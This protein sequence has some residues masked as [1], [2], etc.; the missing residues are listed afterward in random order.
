MSRLAGSTS[1]QIQDAG[2]TLP[3]ITLPMIGASGVSIVALPRFPW[4][5]DEGADPVQFGVDVV[6][7][8]LVAQFHHVRG[9]QIGGRFVPFPLAEQPVIY[10]VIGIAC[11]AHADAG[12][13]HVARVA[14]HVDH[15]AFR[16]DL[17][18]VGDAAMDVQREDPGA[19]GLKLGKEAVEQRQPVEPFGDLKRL[20]LEDA[21][22]A[23][24]G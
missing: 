15:L 24:A 5:A 2:R 17:D 1:Q 7:Q 4:H 8:R 20:G 16:Q 23:Q 21:V 19:L 14:Q 3:F 11:P 12:P 10:P 22:F 9:A 6:E 18:D 13:P